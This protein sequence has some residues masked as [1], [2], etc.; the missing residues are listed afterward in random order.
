MLEEA[1]TECCTPQYSVYVINSRRAGIHGGQS[2]GFQEFTV[3]KLRASLECP[4]HALNSSRYLANTYFFIL[5]L[6]PSWERNIMTGFTNEE[7]ETKRKADKSK[8]GLECGLLTLQT[9]PCPT[10]QT[11]KLLNYSSFIT[12]SS[13]NPLPIS[14]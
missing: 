12:L 1:N 8:L 2:L 5:S 6:Q 9:E 14:K 4:L 3:M 7:N 13:A 10:G 11:S